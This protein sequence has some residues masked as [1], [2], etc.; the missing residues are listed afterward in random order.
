MCFLSDWESRFL[1]DAG[2]REGLLAWSV[3]DSDVLVWRDIRS[4]EGSSGALG[5]HPVGLGGTRVQYRGMEGSDWGRGEVEK[6]VWGWEADCERGK[7][8]CG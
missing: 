4:S 7:S 5:L 2:G 8:D 1:E 3:G 6:K